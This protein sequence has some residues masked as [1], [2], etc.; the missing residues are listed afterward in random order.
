[1]IVVADTS[2][3]NYLV[4]IGEIEIVQKLYQSVV[5]PE[6]V[7]KE[8]QSPFTPPLVLAWC[9]K[10]PA[11]LH[12]QSVKAGVI[13]PDVAVLGSGE[14]AAITLALGQKQ[15]ALLLIDEGK[16]RRAAQ[17]CQIKIIGTLGVLDAA[18]A[19]GLVDLPSALQRL[20]GTTFHVAPQLI[21]KLLNQD[22]ERKRR[23]HGGHS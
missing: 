21:G 4:L 22:T 17:R 7:L 6:E 10:L 15:T 23:S 16:G 13:E 8:L 18:A 9:Q 20:Q 2:P 3:L 1:V 5:I 12:V 19:Q 14:R 11:W